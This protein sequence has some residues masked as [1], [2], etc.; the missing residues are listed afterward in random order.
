MAR[1]PFQPKTDTAAAIEE[2][3]SIDAPEVLTVNGK[4]I[5]EAFAHLI[6]YDVTDQGIAAKQQNGKLKATP[7]VSIGRDAWEKTLDRKADAEVWDGFDPLKEAVDAV[8]EPGMSY[9]F[10]SDRVLNRRGRRGW[11][12]AND[13]DG[14]AVKVAGMTLGKMP[15]ERAERR[16]LH[17]QAVGN[18]QLQNAAQQYE[19]DQTKL[20]RD[21]KVSG[22]SP[23][24]AGERVKDNHQHPGMVM[25]AGVHVARGEEAAA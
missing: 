16:N 15:I 22:M 17:Y 1:K 20:I 6:H 10:I 4:P 3:N 13:Q 24:R 21:A 5:P 19:L 14:K 2:A 23:L 18:D 11:E 25:E 9:R 12:P 7:G 8:R